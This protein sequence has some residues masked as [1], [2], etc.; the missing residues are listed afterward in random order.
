MGYPQIIHFSWIFH[1]KPSILGYPHGHG[2]PH[3][4]IYIYNPQIE[5]LDTVH[6]STWKVRSWESVLWGEALQ[7]PATSL[8][9]KHSALCIIVFRS[10]P[11]SF[12]IAIFLDTKLV[13]FETD[14]SPLTTAPLYKRFTSNTHRKPCIL[15]QMGFGKA[16]RKSPLGLSENRACPQFQSNNHVP[17]INMEV[18]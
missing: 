18:S 9:G 4:C 17:N 1:Y 2:N 15:S 13:N 6:R 8:R 11:V 14:H 10:V 3:A 12:T 7:Q 16:H 5:K